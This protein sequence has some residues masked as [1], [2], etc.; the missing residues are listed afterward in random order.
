M[1]GVSEYRPRPF[2]PPVAAR[3]SCACPWWLWLLLGLLLAALAAL[4]AWKFFGDGDAAGATVK[5][6]EPEPKPEPKPQ[7]EPEPVE[8]T[9]APVDDSKG[10]GKDEIQD[11]VNVN[12]TEVVD[13]K[14]ET[15]PHRCS[16]DFFFYNGECVKCP[17]HS[18]WNRTHCVIRK[19][20]T[21]TTKRSVEVDMVPGESY[22]S[23][24]TATDLS[25]C[26]GG[27]IFG[28]SSGSGSSSSSSDESNLTIGEYM[29]KMGLDYE[30]QQ[31]KWIREGSSGEIHKSKCGLIV[32]PIFEKKKRETKTARHHLRRQR[33]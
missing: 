5:P 4:G 18:G 19:V 33:S 28:S 14:V 22:G 9:P 27:S 24:L 29:K 12:S 13:S 1:V 15:H 2:V 10:K 21:V 16:T 7:P 17:S 11:Q 8:P 25:G 20:N 32:A 31:Q 3:G 26:A 23:S 6:V 30:A